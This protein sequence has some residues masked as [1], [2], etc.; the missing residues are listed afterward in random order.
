MALALLAVGRYFGR[1]NRQE[2]RL[3]GVG[4]DPESTSPA[5]RRLFCLKKKRKTGA[6]RLDRWRVLSWAVEATH[7]FVSPR[8]SRAH[9]YADLWTGVM[10]WFTACSLV[11]SAV[12]CA[13]PTERARLS[14]VSRSTRPGWGAGQG[15]AGQGR[16][17]GDTVRYSGQVS[18]LYLPTVLLSL[19]SRIVRPRDL[20]HASSFFLSFSCLVSVFLLH[21]SSVK[22]YVYTVETEV[23]SVSVTPILTPKPLTHSTSVLIHI[24]LYCFY[25]VFCLYIS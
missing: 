24:G 23:F 6:V 16:T 8:L 21:G 18:S 4:F 25:S 13:P 9:S 20:Y 19:A 15:R 22:M 1:P 17:R 14:L 11:A 7:R 10:A 3:S 5:F 2:L 12:R